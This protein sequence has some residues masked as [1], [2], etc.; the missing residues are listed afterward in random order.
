MT[1]SSF[2][3]LRRS[4]LYIIM[5]ELTNVIDIRNKLNCFSMVA[6]CIRKNTEINGT[7]RNT[8][9]HNPKRTGT[10]INRMIVRKLRL[11]KN[12]IRYTIEY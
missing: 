1:I 8:S 6:S 5:F 7:T 12:T 9:I 10:P 2:L 3:V 4:E 11:T